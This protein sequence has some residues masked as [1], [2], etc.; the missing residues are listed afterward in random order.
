[1]FSFVALT[2]YL[3][4]NRAFCF[5]IYCVAVGTLAILNKCFVYQCG[6]VKELDPCLLFSIYYVGECSLKFISMP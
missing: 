2:H 4:R 5:T 1:M 6:I 3:W